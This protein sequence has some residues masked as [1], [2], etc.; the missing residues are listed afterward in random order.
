MTSRCGQYHVRKGLGCPGL[1][2]PS[3]LPAADGAV[4]ATS[5]SLQLVGLHPGY[6]VPITHL[7]LE[8]GGVE[9]P[10]IPLPPTPHLDEWRAPTVT[11]H[12]TG[13]TPCTEYTLRVRPVVA[14]PLLAATL[15]WSAVAIVRTGAPPPPQ[16][17]VVADRGTDR[18]EVVVN[19]VPGTSDTGVLLTI[20]D[21]P[22]E[23]GEGTGGCQCSAWRKSAPSV[24]YR[25]N[26]SAKRLA[27]QTL[28]F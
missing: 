14:E 2:A 10:P 21:R 5:V 24:S 26:A 20:D 7:V 17:P 27:A 3:V 8:V 22:V 6:N 16:A 25:L 13:L 11:V 23:G 15:G 12:V 1:P 19:V 4:Q 9:R 28:L 18:L